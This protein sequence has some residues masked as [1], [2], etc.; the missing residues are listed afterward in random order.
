[1]AGACKIL[2][3]PTINSPGITSQRKRRKE[4]SLN[5]ARNRRQARLN[6]ETKEQRQVKLEADTETQRHRRREHLHAQR[7]QQSTT[8]ERTKTLD[9]HRKYYQHRFHCE[10]VQDRYRS[11]PLARYNLSEQFKHN[12]TEEQR[13]HGLEELR[14]NTSMMTQTETDQK[15]MEI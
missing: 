15:Q 2:L 3:K 10:L 13:L 9:Y 6:A 8:E 4:R 1:M 14:R 12:E 11:V 5:K 7:R